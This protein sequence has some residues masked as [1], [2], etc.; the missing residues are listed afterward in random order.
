MKTFGWPGT[1]KDLSIR[2]GSKSLMFLALVAVGLVFLVLLIGTGNVRKRALVEVRARL[3]SQEALRVDLVNDREKLLSREALFL[4][5]LP[6]VQEIAHTTRLAAFRSQGIDRE[7]TRKRQLADVFMSFALTNPEILHLRFL[8]V[9]DSGKELVRVDRKNGVLVVVPPGQLD[10]LA[11]RDY[12]IKTALCK[13]GEVY[14]SELKLDRTN[15]S[16]DVPHLPILRAG[17]PIFDK[18][19]ILSGM[20]FVSVDARPMLAEFRSTLMAPFQTYL[21][22]E[23]GDFLSHPREEMDFGFDLGT[24]H[25]WQDEF[26]G[27]GSDDAAPH[28]VQNSTAPAGSVLVVRSRVPLDE[29]GRHLVVV[30]T[31]PES[32]LQATVSRSRN[33]TLAVAVGILGLGGLLL[34]LFLRLQRG[35]RRRIEA[36]NLDLEQQ[37]RDRT[38]EIRS[39]SSLQRAILATAGY[40]IIASD[41]EGII[42]LFN[43]AAE[44][45]LGYSSS[46]VVGHATPLKFRDAQE[47]KTL[48]T[49]LSKKRGVPVSVGFEILLE[50]A[51]EARMGKEWTFVRNDGSRLRV[52][53]TV[54]PLRNQEGDIFGYLGMAVDLTEH[55]KIEEALRAS[56]AEAVAANKSK[57]EF[58]ANMSHEIRTPL[59]AVLG[60]AHVLENRA[61]EP[62]MRDLVQKIRRAGT[63]L[64]TLID[65]VLDF[66]KIEAGHLEL[67]SAAFRLD[68]VLDNL[69][70]IMGANAGSKNIELVIG[71][72]PEGTTYMVGDS[73]RLEQVLI[74]LTGNAIKF[75]ERGSVTV[76]M[77]LVS[78][79]EDEATLR[80]SVRDTGIGIPLDKQRTIFDS[81]SQADSSTTRRFGGT[82]LGLAICRLLVEKMGGAIE[83]RSVEGQG[84]EFLFT[85][86]LHKAQPDGTDAL[87]LPGLHVLVA[88][89]NELSLDAIAAVATSIGWLVVAVGSGNEAIEETL[90]RARSDHPFDVLLLDWK[91]PEFDGLST[92][93]ELRARLENRTPPI[94]LLATAYSREE[95]ARCPES[96]CVDGILSKPLTGSSL[97]N[98]VVGAQHRRKSRLPLELACHERR[99]SGIRVL[100]VDDN[101]TIRGLMMAIFED[102][103]ATV[104]LAENGEIAVEWLRANPRSV[105]IVLMDVQMPVMDGYAAARAI[106][107][108]PLIADL[109]IVALSAGVFRSEQE[110]ALES[111]MDDFLPKPFQ[112]EDLVRVI[113][114]L[115]GTM[116]LTHTAP[117]KRPPTTASS[118]DAIDLAFGLS[119]WK[120]RQVFFGRLEKFAAEYAGFAQDVASYLEAG[121]V[122]KVSFALHRLKGTAG[123]LAMAD[124]AAQAER[125]GRLLHDGGDPRTSL[126]EFRDSMDLALAA[127]PAMVATPS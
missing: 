52:L 74:N 14:L 75:T 111:G 103:G 86:V 84:C 48:A 22:N 24:L 127:I 114:H 46:E 30:A 1:K 36:L 45:M 69:A 91:M 117:E 73:H 100:V 17:A 89:D 28:W 50:D 6:T 102:E 35:V 68:D 122:R 63:S 126:A 55:N 60:L 15:G 65:D 33:A 97:Y 82:G 83:V 72:A 109:P 5:S 62:D 71:A 105:D 66:S 85:I 125:L 49:E 10:R 59:S 27:T 77:E 104:N 21:T 51:L 54:R 107:S 119:Q 19:G 20:I 88:D 78:M 99:L 123:A 58:L 41:T 47:M 4:V 79:V 64:Q 92:V 37:V 110:A 115:T 57:A 40:A 44:A 23:R 39:Y 32:G 3:A 67:E 106:R 38:A 13:P 118:E 81:F 120:T 98:A 31:Y 96:R 93:L 70:T 12:F 94:V 25:R 90:V 7:M 87:P 80:F 16:V 18:D 53:L 42:T 9:A 29:F 61:L 76:S 11:D 124:L 43:P 121:D 113:L 95:L 101:E 2:W 8:G 116:M 34:F 108:T 112:V 26:Q 56:T